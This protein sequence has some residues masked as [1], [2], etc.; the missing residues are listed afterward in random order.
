MKLSIIGGN[1]NPSYYDTH[2]IDV[3]SELLDRTESLGEVY[4]RTTVPRIE[5]FHYSIIFAS[6]VSVCSI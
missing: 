4:I 5:G 6:D 2:L 3:M 1:I